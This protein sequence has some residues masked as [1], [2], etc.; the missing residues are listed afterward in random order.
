VEGR[1]DV[2]AGLLVED[3]EEIR[4]DLEVEATPQPEVLRVVE[5]ELPV[6][7]RAT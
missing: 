5:V 1:L 2:V 3:V 7:I 4:G 6:R